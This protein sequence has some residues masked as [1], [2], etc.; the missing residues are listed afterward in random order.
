MVVSNTTDP[1]H[2]GSISYYFNNPAPYVEWNEHN[3][4]WEGASSNWGP[5]N[6]DIFVKFW[7]TGT[8]DSLG[9]PNFNIRIHSLVIVAGTTYAGSYLNCQAYCFEA[10]VAGR[11]GYNGLEVLGFEA[12]NYE[13]GPYVK[14][15]EVGN[16]YLSWSFSPLVIS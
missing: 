16:Q 1:N 2:P 15:P 3:G 10:C 7:F 9:T 6:C 11:T 8:P 5:T 12:A 13:G 14:V 4:C